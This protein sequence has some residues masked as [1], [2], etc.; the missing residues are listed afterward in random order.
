MSDEH[1]LN[2]FTGRALYY[3]KA[4]PNYPE[5][6]VLHIRGLAPRGA[7]FA[8]IGAGTGKFTV[9][10]ASYGNRIFAVEPNADMRGQ[11]TLAVAGYQNVIVSSGTAEATGLDCGCA[12]VVVCAQS[13]NKFDLDAFK[14]ECLRIGREGLVVAALYNRTSGKLEN[15]SQYDRSTGAFFTNPEVREFPNPV[16]FTRESWLLYHLSMDGVPMENETGHAKYAAELDA[17]FDRE[18]ADGILLHE[19][20]TVVYSERI[21]R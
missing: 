5:G 4:R 21:K 9:Q 11:L 17:A 10:L 6:A 3:A 20:T 15:T 14:K 7:A 12:D 16:C 13:L 18:S 2:A 1:N 19:L 8:D